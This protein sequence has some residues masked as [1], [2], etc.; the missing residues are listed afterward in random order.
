[1][2]LH[3]VLWCCACAAWRSSVNYIACIPVL[4]PRVCRMLM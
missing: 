3:A 4:V 2:Y 1:M